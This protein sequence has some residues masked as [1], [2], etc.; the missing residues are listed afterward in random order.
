MRAA[1]LVVLEAT[2]GYERCAVCAMH[3]AGVVAAR[4]NPRQARDS[5]KSMGA[6][7]K[8]DE[9]DAR[10]LEALVICWLNTK[11]VTSS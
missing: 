6:L 3:Q 2:G 1:D 10:C 9:V 5:A 8:T 11:S 4:V 7:A